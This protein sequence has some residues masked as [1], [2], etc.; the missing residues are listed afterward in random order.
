[1]SHLIDHD[2]FQKRGGHGTGTESEQQEQP[3]PTPLSSSAPSSMTSPLLPSNSH[4][5]KGS[6]DVSR[7]MIRLRDSMGGSGTS[8]SRNQRV[9]T[10]H[11]SSPNHDN[12]HNKNKSLF[13]DQEIGITGSSQEQQQRQQQRTNNHK[14]DYD[15]FQYSPTSSSSLLSLALENC[16][17]YHESKDEELSLL[18]KKMKTM[19]NHDHSHEYNYNQ[20]HNDHKE[21]HDKYEE[22]LFNNAFTI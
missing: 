8:V 12:N 22:H 3:P 1:M 2:Q 16:D 4:R 20:K 9:D 13:L 18:G 21:Q 19:K 15:T 11:P 17:Q 5:K 7:T 10:F 6:Y 14:R